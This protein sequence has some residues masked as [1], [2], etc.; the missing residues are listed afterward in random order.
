MFLSASPL[1]RNRW[2]E[3][4]VTIKGLRVEIFDQREKILPALDS[5]QDGTAKNQKFSTAKKGFGGF[6]NSILS[7][8][9]GRHRKI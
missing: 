7:P 9:W 5:H 6:P 8:R 1:Q 2:T 4:V 3:K